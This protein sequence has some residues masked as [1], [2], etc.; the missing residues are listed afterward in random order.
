ML[1]A[2][3]DMDSRHLLPLALTAATGVWRR[4]GVGVCWDALSPDK[5]AMRV[6]TQ[7]VRTREKGLHIKAVPKT[8]RTRRVLPLSADLVLLLKAHRAAQAA[9]RLKAGADWTDH[10]LAFTTETGRIVE[11]RNVLRTIMAAAKKAGVDGL[12]VHTL[13]HSA[14]TAWLAG[15]THIVAVAELLGHSCIAITGD[16]YGHADTETARGAVNRL[17]DALDLSAFAAER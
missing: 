8:E 17:S 9:E 1:Q 3:R 13:R 14:A 2:V 11:P 10:G 4:E 5:G 15:G 16:L 12:A 6:V 7:A